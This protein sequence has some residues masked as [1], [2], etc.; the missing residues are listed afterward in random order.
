[1]KI[2]STADIHRYSPPPYGITENNLKKLH[3]TGL[4]EKSD[5]SR[6]F[7]SRVKHIFYNKNCKVQF[8]MT[9]ISHASSFGE[10][11]FFALESLFKTN[12]TSCLIILSSSMDS[13]KGDKI[14]KPLISR[15]FRVHAIT[16]DLWDL[17]NKTPA[18]NWLND[19]MNG[20]KNP[21]EIPLAQ[22]L[23]NLI[24]LAV[25]YKYGG[26]Y[27]D[28]D[29]IILKDFSSLRN[30]IGAQSIDVNG[31][32]TR[33]NNAVLVF[34]KNHPLIYKFIEEF[35]LSFDG[36][37]WGYN[38][39]YLVSR[40]VDRVAKTREFNFTILPPMAFYPVDWTRISGFFI[41][42]N[43]PVGAEWVEAKIRH[44]E[45][46]TYGV[47]LWNRESSRFKIE[48]GSIIGRLISYHC[49]ICRKGL[50]AL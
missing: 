45:R 20:N 14:L 1:M 41:R 18:E 21:G 39:P 30:T 44:L 9:W 23:S 38:G 17:F 27:L 35:A 34:D 47:H 48:E 26:V 40:V 5:S 10:R 8:F 13:T 32:W 19:I 49:V 6:E 50:D 36:N 46:V 37:I 11:E 28:T 33:L 15:G 43:D 4:F 7:D 2:T 25:L 12:P 22:N 24:R 3:E 16:P 31:K 29:F 42:Y